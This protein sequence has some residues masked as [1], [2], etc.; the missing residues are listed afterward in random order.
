ML[1]HLARNVRALA[2]ARMP[3]SRWASD[4]LTQI[5]ALFLAWHKNSAMGGVTGLG[6][7][8]HSS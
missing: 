5:D 8:R 2:E 1:A 4:V 3:E 6:C 7:R